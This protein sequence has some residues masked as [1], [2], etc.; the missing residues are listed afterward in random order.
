MEAFKVD[1]RDIEWEADVAT[2]RVIFR[3]PIS[4]AS[5][6]WEIESESSVTRVVAWAREM[7]RGRDAE[8]FVVVP[9]QGSLGQIRLET[10]D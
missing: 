3:D 6:E 8:V 2:F 1:P 7:R 10:L 9:G 5:E 4:D